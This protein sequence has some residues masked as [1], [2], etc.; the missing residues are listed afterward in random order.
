MAT[1][2]NASDRA[3]QRFAAEV[4]LARREVD[5]QRRRLSELD[6]GRRLA[7][8]GNALT[9][10]KFA[11]RSGLD[12]FSAA[13]AAL[14]MVVADNHDARFVREEMAPPADQLIER[15]S[16]EGFGEPAYVRASDV[17]ARL[18]TTAAGLQP[19]NLIESKFN[20]K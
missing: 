20:L 19:S 17:L 8:I 7:R 18:R 3:S 2:I 16:D 1:D 14:A 10:T 9:A 5:A 15:M 4:A 12:S 6:R 13:E 11:S